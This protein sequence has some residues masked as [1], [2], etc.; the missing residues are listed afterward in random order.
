MPAVMG[1]RVSLL[2]LVSIVIIYE[3]MEAGLEKLY[4]LL[5]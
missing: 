4:P 1:L 3:Q 2:K 5:V